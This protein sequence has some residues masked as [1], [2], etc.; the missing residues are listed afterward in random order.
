LEERYEIASDAILSDYQKIRGELPEKEAVIA[1]YFGVFT[2]EELFGIIDS[3]ENF[4]DEKGK[5]VGF[6]RRLIYLIIESIQNIMF[7]SEKKISVKPKSYV[8]VY[9][10]DNVYTVLT[11][12]IIETKKVFELKKNLT[13]L[14]SLESEKLTKLYEEKIQNPKINKEKHG[15]LGLISMTHKSGQ[16]FSYD[17][18][19]ISEELSLF[20]FE[21]KLQYKINAWKK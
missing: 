7:H 19:E 2:Q 14:L 10:C 3:V 20:R 9:E 11:S 18:V 1:E 6:E 16:E 13:T 4:C 8:V 15:G 5:S 17:M 12:N 21:L